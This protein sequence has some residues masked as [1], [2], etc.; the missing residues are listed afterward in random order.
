M[1]ATSVTD[2]VSATSAGGRDVE[3]GTA[4]AGCVNGSVSASTARDLA[5]AIDIVRAEDE[6]A[7]SAEARETR[8]SLEV[9]YAAHNNRRK[10]PLNDQGGDTEFLAKK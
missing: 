8:E 6:S 5:L 2:N 4:V 7:R 10:P 9:T 3:V 1:N